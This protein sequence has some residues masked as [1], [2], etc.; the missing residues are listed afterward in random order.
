MW[1]YTPF[2]ASL[3]VPEPEV[4]T[5][6][7]TS[8]SPL[9]TLSVMS[10]TTPSPQPLS[11]RG[12]QTRVWVKRLCGTILNPLMA[13]HG[14]ALLMSSLRATRASLSAW[15][16]N[17]KA[18]PTPD[19]SGP[20]LPPPSTQSDPVLCSAKTSQDTSP[21][22]FNRSVMTWT[23]WVTGLRRAC[24][25]RRKQVQATCGNAY[26]SLPTAQRSLWPTPVASNFS[27]RAELVYQGQ[28]FRLRPSEKAVKRNSGYQMSLQ[29]ATEQVTL[30]LN[31]LRGLGVKSPL[32]RQASTLPVQMSL[33]TGLGSP[34]LRYN[35]QFGEWMMGWPIGWTDPDSSVTGFAQWQQRMRGALSKLP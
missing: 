3:C 13:D 18:H 12:W 4:L 2:T 25:Q 32:H 27:N 21:L 29:K 31:L 7:S 30:F 9:P 20:M 6:A 1:L 16:D 10:S 19:T 22:V 15:P 26:S 34:P 33:M 24:L 17:A 28:H 14:A 5:S 35:P 11:W 23:G 8:P